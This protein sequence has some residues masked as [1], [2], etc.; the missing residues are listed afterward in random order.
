M[1]MNMNMGYTQIAVVSYIRRLLVCIHTYTGRKAMANHNSATM[2]MH[3]N[4][5]I[6]I[7]IYIYICIYMWVIH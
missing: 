6:Y 4:I 1:N 7:Y 3:Q 5:Y 2:C